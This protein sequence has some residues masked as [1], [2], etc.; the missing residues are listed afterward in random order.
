ML[1]VP[2]ATHA[3]YHGICAGWRPQHP[4]LLLMMLRQA[5]GEVAHGHVRGEATTHPSDTVGSIQAFSIETVRATKR[6]GETAPILA[7]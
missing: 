2:E 3:D 6:R 5:S 1:W 4:T 7:I